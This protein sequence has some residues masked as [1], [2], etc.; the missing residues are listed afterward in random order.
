[1]IVIARWMA[2]H[3][4]LWPLANNDN[5]MILCR[6]RMYSWLTTGI[7]QIAWLHSTLNDDLDDVSSGLSCF[8]SQ[9]TGHQSSPSCHYTAI[10]VQLDEAINIIIVVIIYNI[11]VCQGSEQLVLIELKWL[12]SGFL[13]A[14]IFLSLL[15]K[16]RTYHDVQK[17][18]IDRGF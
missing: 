12:V 17:S 11:S 16:L 2:W 9:L 3:F 4:G 14:G 1:M 15:E 7:R 6:D 5:C 13:Q 8:D 18:R 10:V